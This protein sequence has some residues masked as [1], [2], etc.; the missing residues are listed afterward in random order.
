MPRT[1]APGRLAVAAADKRARASERPYHKFLLLFGH[2][3]CRIKRRAEQISHSCDS[4]FII[5]KKKKKAIH[6]RPGQP[7]HYR[8]QR[9]E[10]G[11]NGF[12]FWSVFV[13]LWRRYWR[14]CDVHHTRLIGHPQVL[15]AMWDG[16]FKFPPPHRW[17]AL[18]HR[19][20]CV[21]DYI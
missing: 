7:T 15:D 8:C 19:R 21:F 17:T 18:L 2:F 20:V 9:P 6:L 11:S 14:S 13:S 1:P 12:S 16:G 3:A 10:S 4:F 5:T